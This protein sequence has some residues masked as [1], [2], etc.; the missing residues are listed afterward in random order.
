MQFVHYTV[1]GLGYLQRMNFVTQP[2]V[3]LYKH[4]TNGLHAESQKLGG[5]EKTQ[6][7]A[8]LSGSDR[9]LRFRNSIT[10]CFDRLPDSVPAVGEDA[11]TVYANMIRALAN[12]RKIEYG[13]L[14]FFG[15]MRYSAAGRNIRKVLE[16]GGSKI[17]RSA[18]KMPVDV[19]EGP[20][21]NHSYHEMIIGHGRCFST[22]L[23][24]EKA[25]KLAAADYT[26]DYHRAQFLATQMALQQRGRFVVSLLV[27]DL[28]EPTLTALDEFF[29]LAANQ[30]KNRSRIR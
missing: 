18:M 13:E 2:G 27:K 12:D 15:D 28:E 19:Y 24:A 5:I 29:R 25:D 20:A 22:V 23:L 4:I 17:F 3:E 26:A 1:F 11:P 10:L 9:R 6:E 7:W 30:L 8:S 21:M 14:T 16:R